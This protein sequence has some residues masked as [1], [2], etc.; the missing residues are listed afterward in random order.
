MVSIEFSFHFD[1]L[2]YS[3]LIINF[4][5][6][7]KRLFRP[8]KILLL[9]HSKS[10]YQIQLYKLNLMCEKLSYQIINTSAVNQTVFCYYQKFAKI[11]IKKKTLVWAVASNAEIFLNSFMRDLAKPI[12]IGF[13]S[14]EFLNIHIFNQYK[15]LYSASSS[16]FQH[17]DFIRAIR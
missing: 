1:F 11:I 2:C 4:P 15:A 13:G 10:N 3:S 14:C 5:R 7:L 9:T 12:W 8:M 17:L 6:F 16:T